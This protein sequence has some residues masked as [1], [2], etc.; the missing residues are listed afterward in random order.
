MFLATNVPDKEAWKDIKIQTTRNIPNNKMEE[1]QM[2]SQLS[3]IVSHKTQLSVLSI[4]DDPDKELERIEEEDEGPDQVMTQY[5]Q[6]PTESQEPQEP[7]QP[8]Q[9]QEDEV[10]AEE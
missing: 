3:G 4:V 10:N 2:A 8:Q 1:A 7:Q 5:F 9:P 6:Q